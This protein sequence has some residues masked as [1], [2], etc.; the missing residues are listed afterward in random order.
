M[1][2]SPAYLASEN[3][4]NHDADP[5]IAC[6]VCGGGVRPQRSGWQCIRCGLALC[7]GCEGSA[8]ECDA[9]G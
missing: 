4:R 3:P 8:G 2:T 9:E 7:E 1:T 6:P 5:A